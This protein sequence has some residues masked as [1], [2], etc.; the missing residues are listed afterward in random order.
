MTVE[1][2]DMQTEPDFGAPPDLAGITCPPT[3]SLGA[4]SKVTGIGVSR[5]GLT[6][7][8]VG[9]SV[10]AIEGKDP[11]DNPLGT[12][13]KATDNNGTLAAF[14]NVGMAEPNGRERHTSTIVAGKL[15]TIGGI[16]SGKASS[17]IGIT[18]FDGNGDPGAWSAGN[19]LVE[20]RYG[21]E[22]VRSGVW[23]YVLGGFDDNVGKNIYLNTV[24]R[25]NT[26]DAAATFQ[27]FATT[28]TKARSLGGA[29]ATPQYLYVIGGYNSTDGILNTV[30]R[31]PVDANGGISGNFAIVNGVTLKNPRYQFA[32]LRVGDS[33]FI[34]GGN[35]GSQET[36][37]IEMATIDASGNLSDFTELLTVTLKQARIGPAA[38]VV[39]KDV[40]VFGGSAPVSLGTVA[41]SVEKA[42]LTP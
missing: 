17:S 20:A 3:C 9:N 38:V 1:Q 21:H 36:A 15:Y 22:G 41:S 10:Y 14:A 42:T 6:A 16:Y 32:L 35:S 27:Q 31:A 4:F 40:F 11:V 19:G 28:M 37:S 33:V 2:S 18:T 5:T 26:S 8:V 24:E 12:V 30:E 7:D 13:A 34:I 29:V 39:G 25:W 23:Y